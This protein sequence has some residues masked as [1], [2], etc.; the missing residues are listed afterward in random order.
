MYDKHGDYIVKTLEEVS[1]LIVINRIEFML[2]MLKQASTD[3][4]R[5]RVPAPAIGAA[6]IWRSEVV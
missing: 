1:C 3:V 2:T 6:R 4:I 5:T